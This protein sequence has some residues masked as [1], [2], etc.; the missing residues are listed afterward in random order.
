LHKIPHIREF[1]KNSNSYEKYNFLQKKIAKKLVKKVDFFPRSILDIGCGDG[2]VFSLIDWDFKRFV[3]VDL[4]QEMLKKHPKNEKVKLIKKDFDK[5][6]D[7]F[8]KD[9]DLVV[10]SSAL[11]WSSNP[12]EYI[13]RLQENSKSFAVSIFCDKTFLDV[14]KYL[15]VGT[16]LPSSEKLIS[17]LSEKT[18]Y[19]VKNYQIT[20]KDNISLLR[21]I[22]K[23]GVS[24]GVK[25]TS[26]KML[27]DF[28]KN[29]KTNTLEF[30]VL[31]M[32]KTPQKSLNKTQNL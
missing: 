10:S 24:G 26:V 12:Y 17:L 27:R 30:E 8:F 22:K 29:Y 2:V 11:Q 19:E 25:K 31:F 32:I 13:S 7:E 23:S 28:I 20:F 5:L 1:S 14:R 6:E 4:S 18:K 9:F 21:Y 16:F 15:G 3:G